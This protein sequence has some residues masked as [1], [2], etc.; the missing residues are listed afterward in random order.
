MADAT[1]TRSQVEALGAKLDGIDFTDEERSMLQAVFRAAGGEGEVE[2]F[3][4]SQALSQALSVGLLGAFQL[5]VQ[6]GK[7]D[8]KGKGEC[9]TDGKPMEKS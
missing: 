3:A 6:S 4:L 2:G 1:F 7:L 5:N 9:R 8:C